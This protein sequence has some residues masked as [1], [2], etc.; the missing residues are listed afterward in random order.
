MEGWEKLCDGFG[1]VASGKVSAE[2]IVFTVSL[3]PRILICGWSGVY[4]L[5]VARL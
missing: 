4:G 3:I 1:Y 2:S 5:Y